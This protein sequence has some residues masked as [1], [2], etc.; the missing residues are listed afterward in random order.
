[1]SGPAQPPNSS[2]IRRNS[3]FDPDYLRGIVQR[4]KASGMIQVPEEVPAVPKPEEKPVPMG[5][6]VDFDFTT[7]NKVLGLAINR[8][9]TPMRISRAIHTR[10]DAMTPIEKADIPIVVREMIE[11]LRHTILG[12]SPADPGKPVVAEITWVSETS[13]KITAPRFPDFMLRLERS[14]AWSHFR[15]QLAWLQ[16]ASGELLIQG[17]VVQSSWMHDEAT[18]QAKGTTLLSILSSMQRFPSTMT[19]I[20]QELLDADE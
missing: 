2:T 9:M 7:L 4:A 5:A 3:N 17:A 8:A 16:I 10:L 1:M 14:L 6:F 15:G 11:G 13:A 12:T 20:G 19:C 18:G